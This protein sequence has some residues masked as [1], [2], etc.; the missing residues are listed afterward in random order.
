MSLATNFMVFLH[1]GKREFGEQDF[2]VILLMLA[3]K[4]KVYVFCKK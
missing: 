1:V 4:K 2:S 3:K